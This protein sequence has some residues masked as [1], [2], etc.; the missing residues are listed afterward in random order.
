MLVAPPPG[1]LDNPL[2]QP[3]SLGADTKNNGKYEPAACEKETPKHRKLGKMRRQRNM[4]QMKE[5]GKNKTEQ[6]APNVILQH[7]FKY[8]TVTCK[9]R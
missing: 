1:S 8:Y 9:C 6:K 5:Q 2:N 3:H 4:Q 7:T